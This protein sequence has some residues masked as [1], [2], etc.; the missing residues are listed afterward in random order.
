[1]SGVEERSFEREDRQRDEREHAH[2]LPGIFLDTQLHQ[3]G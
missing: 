1:M 2:A 3:K